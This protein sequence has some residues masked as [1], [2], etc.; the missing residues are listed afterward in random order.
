MRWYV[1]ER[2]ATHVR[3]GADPEVAKPSPCSQIVRHWEIAAIDAVLIAA[4]SGTT[5]VVAVATA[6][7]PFLRWEPL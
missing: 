4:E 7:E 3:V 5:P 2:L 1:E 6:H